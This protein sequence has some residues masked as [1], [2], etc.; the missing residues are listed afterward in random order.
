[1]RARW[2][3]FN[4]AIA[5]MLTG[6]LC[7]SCSRNSE[8]PAELEKVMTCQ[9]VPVETFLAIT[10][11]SSLGDVR[12]LVGNA[13]RHQFTVSVDGHKWMLIRCFIHTGEDEGFNFKQLL[14]RDDAL[15][16]TIG[17]FPMEM[18]RYPY[19]GTTATRI[20]QWDIADMKYVKKAMA[21]PLVTPDQIRA[22][23]EDARQIM[24]ESKG[25][26]NIPAVVGYALAPGFLIKARKAY[27]LNEE[28]R[29]R[30]DGS[31]ATIGMTV[32]Q[33]DR[34]Y[35]KPVHVFTTG[36]GRRARIYGDARRPEV[37]PLLC[38]S[39][40]AVLFDLDGKAESV[41]SDLFFCNDWDKVLQEPNM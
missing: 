6:G 10:N 13:V 16:K 29:R 9:F 20:K 15:I 39:Y 23:I 27:P 25:Q 1:M 7:L 8:M 22:E 37:Q 33:V 18:E 21:A 30:F 5:V 24:S 17:W 3:T 41:Y 32:D 4:I 31:R 34:L 38:F 14:F 11:G 40:V 28:L 35:G 19:G 12:K 36:T 26:G 2:N